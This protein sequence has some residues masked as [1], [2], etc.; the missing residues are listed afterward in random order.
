MKKILCL[1]LV[2]VL[3]FACVSCNKD[4]NEDKDDDKGNTTVT[5]TP[6]EAFAAFE[7]ALTKANAKNVVVSTVT[8]ANGEELN[9][10]FNVHFAEDGSATISG[11]YERFYGIGEGPDDEIKYSTPVTFYRDKDG[12][13]TANNGVDVSSVEAAAALNISSLKASA[14]ISADYEVLTVSVAKDATLGVFGVAFNEDV[15]LT[16]TLD[17]TDSLEAISVVGGDLEISIKYN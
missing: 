6:D 16:I 17:A 12:K 14:T 8:K 15:T 2:L 3:A 11:S 1:L 13:Y 7:S 10:E 9:A 5:K 4:K